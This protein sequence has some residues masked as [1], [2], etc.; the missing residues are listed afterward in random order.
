MKK[1]YLECPEDHPH[2]G[3]IR[4]D[5]NGDPIC[6]ICGKSFPKLGAHIWSGHKIRTRDYCELFGLDVGRGICSKEYANKMR[7]YVHE[8]YQIVVSENLIRGGKATRF[9]QGCEGRTRDKISE[10]TKKALSALGKKTG[11]M[12]IKKTPNHKKHV[13]YDT[14]NQ[15]SDPGYK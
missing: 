1:D 14:R 8:H 6:H 9:K 15:N 5:V 4:Y 10:Q 12:N 7:G 13:G 2:Y 11:A 3:E